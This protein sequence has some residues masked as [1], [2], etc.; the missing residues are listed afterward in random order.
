M[1]RAIDIELQMANR[2]FE[3][4]ILGRGM[5]RLP[6]DSHFLM[7]FKQKNKKSNRHLYIDLGRSPE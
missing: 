1:E 6:Y 5:R 3:V 4:P 7:F 2:L